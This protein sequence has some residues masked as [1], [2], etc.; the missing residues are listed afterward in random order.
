[1][2]ADGV[3]A[4]SLDDGTAPVTK[5]GTAAACECTATAGALASECKVI[6]SK[7]NPIR[8]SAA[9]AFC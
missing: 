2:S 6:I 4:A 5:E 1:M 9:A 8:A 3:D 7:G